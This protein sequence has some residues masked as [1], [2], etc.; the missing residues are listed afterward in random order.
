MPYREIVPKDM[1][2]F[3]ATMMNSLSRD[4]SLTFAERATKYLRHNGQPVQ[5]RGYEWQ[6]GIL[7]D[8]HPRQAIPKPSQV[9]ATQVIQWK[10]MLFADQYAF[11]PFFYKSDEG[12]EM[13]HYPTVIYTLESDDKVGEYS[14]DRLGGFFRDNPYFDSLL[15]EGEVDQVRLKKFGR[16]AVYFGGR[17][18]VSSVTTVPGD[19]VI[20]DEWDR[21]FEIDVGEQIPS[22][23]RHSPMFRSKTYRGMMIKFS[24][25]EMENFGVTKEY[26][27]LSDQHEFMVKCSHCSHWQTMIYPDSIANWYEKGQPPSS[28]LYYICLACHRPLDW[29][30]IGGWKSSEPNV[31]H[32]CEWVPKRKEFYETVTRYGEGVRGYRIPWAYS[33]PV[34]E[35]MTERDG[36]SVRYFHHH[37]LGIP[38]E[39][40]KSGLNSALFKTFPVCVF[41]YEPG[42]T[43]IAGIDQGAYVCV[44]RYIPNSR[45]DLAPIGRWEIVHVEFTPDELAFKTF[46]TV[47]GQISVRE[48]RISQILKQF[49]CEL[50]VCDAEPSGNDASNLQ[51]DFPR[52]VFVNHSTRMNIDDPSLGFKWVDEEK[53]PGGQSIFVGRISEDKTGAFDAYSDFLYQGY[54][55]MPQQE[56][57]EVIGKMISH[58]LN[59]KRTIREEKQTVGKTR[60]TRK[61]QYE[62]IWYSVGPD[63]YAHANKFAFQAASLMWRLG[64]MNYTSLVTDT[65]ISGVKWPER[66]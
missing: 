5:F 27:E 34:H 38:Y 20:C 43:Y 49:H 35:I 7:N 65:K 6:I 63:H 29:S 40:K 3:M 47:D 64:R 45:G 48:G 14:A 58:H 2:P 44:W 4:Y 18:T 10:V 41:G 46:Q 52:T 60:S 22:R 1:M 55:A 66:K 19:I 33:R 50:A 11:M 57:E 59:L 28:D 8:F 53:D 30:V 54:L 26:E 21:T 42:Y 32:N 13:A 36:N 31:T 37:V 39:D 62:T 15:S 61:V 25:P 17:K 12:V 9:G 51:K 24:S 16:T 23:L 56:A